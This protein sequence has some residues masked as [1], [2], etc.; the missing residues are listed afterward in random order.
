MIQVTWGTI[1]GVT[2]V[3]GVAL[4]G[5]YIIGRM[6]KQVDRNTADIQEIF[7]KLGT[8]YDYVK[9]GHPSKS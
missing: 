3:L 5:A 7:S 6:S 9:N 1:V 8:I 2:A 4:P